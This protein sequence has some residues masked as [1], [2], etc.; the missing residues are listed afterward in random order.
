VG[1]RLAAGDAALRGEDWAR[2][3]QAYRGILE[4]TD[5]R[6]AMVLNN[7]AYAESQLGNSAEALRLARRALALAPQNASVLDTP[8]G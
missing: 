2:A 7:L 6:N 3:A 1:N 4:V 8:G 5:G